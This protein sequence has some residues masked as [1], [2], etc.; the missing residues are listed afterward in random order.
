[1]EG[2]EKIR[3][4]LYIKKSFDGYRVVYPWKNDDGTSNWFNILVG[5][6]WWSLI[7]VSILVFIILAVSWSYAHDTKS[8]R[9]LINDPCKFLPTI[10]SYCSQDTNNLKE[11]ILYDES[12]QSPFVLVPPTEVLG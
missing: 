2:I 6:T 3:E 1:M 10:N 11:G 8:C 7:K 4:G 5:G 9:E 12:E